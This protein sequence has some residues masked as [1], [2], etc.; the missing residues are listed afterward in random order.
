MIKQMRMI[1]QMGMKKCIYLRVRVVRKN[2]YGHKKVKMCKMYLL[3]VNQLFPKK[4][5]KLKTNGTTNEKWGKT[6]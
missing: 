1:K 3:K 4:N 2:E 5:S 6:K